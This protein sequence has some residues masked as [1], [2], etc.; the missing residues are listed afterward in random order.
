MPINF[1]QWLFFRR[2]TIHKAVYL[3]YKGRLFLNFKTEPDKSVLKGIAF[4]FCGLHRPTS[5][6]P[7]SDPAYVE[8]KLQIGFPAI[9]NHYVLIFCVCLFVV[10]LISNCDTELFLESQWKTST[11]WLCFVLN[12]FTFWLTSRFMPPPNVGGYRP[13]AGRGYPGRH[14]RSFTR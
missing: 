8:R 7:S 1:L 10:L 9:N 3:G 2:W 6:A 5:V 11:A 4:W 14:M 13:G 12:S